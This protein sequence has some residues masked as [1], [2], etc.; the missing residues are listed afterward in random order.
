MHS[1][2][3]SRAS[4]WL[5]S[6]IGVTGQGQDHARQAVRR[7]GTLAL[8]LAIL[9]A[10]GIPARQ[11][12]AHEGF[13][14]P[15]EL[16]LINLTTGTFAVA[17]VVVFVLSR[18]PKVRPARLLTAGLFYEVALCLGGAMLEQQLVE[19][20]ELPP[21]VSYVI[22]V[23]LLFPVV[24][25]TS[26]VR[27]A[28]TTLAA[29]ASLPVATVILVAAGTV[30][31]PEPTVAAY[32][33]MAFTMAAL[34]IG[35]SRIVHA[36][37]E[38]AEKARQLGSYQLVDKIGGGAMGE[39]WRARHRLL[40]RPAAI[41]LIKDSALGSSADSARARFEREAQATSAL[42]SPHTVMLYD[43]GLTDRGT[44][45]YA[46]E[47]LDGLD[48]D[49][50][51]NRHGPMDAGRAVHI[52]KQVCL[53]LSE[54]HAAGLVHRDIKPANIFLCRLGQEVD[55][56]KVLDFGL[57][58][59]QQGS[60]DGVK[61]SAEHVATGTPAFMP[62]ELA[63]GEG[64]I[65]G[66][67]DLYSVGCV[68]YWLLTGQLVFQADSAMKMLMAHCKDAPAPPSQ[69]AELEVPGGLD[70]II[71]SCLAKSPSDRPADA[72]A[73]YD[74]LAGLPPSSGWDDH[75]A[76]EWWDIHAPPSSVLPE[77]DDEL[78]PNDEPGEARI[79]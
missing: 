59:P 38:D 67:A 43:F 13:I 22:A 58:K 64:N 36:L 57:V 65:D 76:S 18:R 73:L 3:P 44:L 14:P 40:V 25:P 45:Y 27:R 8:F 70:A 61:L 12:A 1:S 15:D 37:A 24:V 79:A 68:G 33:F 46:M 17:S 30:A 50:L 21:R 6:R 5:R 51:V 52:L 69:S 74:R 75:R 23:L 32:Y 55:F 2:A 35:A 60:S 10:A 41:K 9:F 34:A 7:L 11:L 56:V 71:L 53:S 29:A 20:D 54:A 26:K 16:M 72:K 66:R 47:L 62:P 78:D 48:L 42:R 39:V 4:T 49:S 77:E 19:V 28:V 63:L 31:P